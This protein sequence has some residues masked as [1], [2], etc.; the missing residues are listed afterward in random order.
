MHV[1]EKKTEVRKLVREAR[2]GGRVL[3]LVPTMGAL[4]EGHLALVRS[5]RQAT[6]HVTV[7][8]FV[9]PTQFGAGEDLDRYPADLK[10]DLAKLESLNVDVVFAPTVSEMYPTNAT[11]TVVVE[12]AS[13]HLCGKFRPGHFEGVTSVVAKLFAICDP[14][15]AVFGLKDAQQY[16]IIRRMVGDLGWGID[17][18]G[19]P[20]VREDDGLALSSRNAYLGADERHQ[21]VVVSKAV[22]AA[23]D[24]ILSGERDPSTIEAAMRKEVE[25]APEAIL[26]YAQLVSTDTIAPI[27][28]LDAGSS[29]LAAIAVYL[30]TTR[31]ID[32]QFVIAP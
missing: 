26:Q 31:L 23:R 4:H 2:N 24:L 20:T 12:G 29:V 11:T 8:I 19:V 21:A 18:V 22:F 15:N 17:V 32:N 7:S 27:R 16:L 30:G 25:Q 10:G 1:V 28:K 6:D 13:E 5:A 3:G 9:N 14:D